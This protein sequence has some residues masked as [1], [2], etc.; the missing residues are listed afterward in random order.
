MGRSREISIQEVAQITGW[1]QSSIRALGVTGA[2]NIY[3]AEHGHPTTRCEDARR[4]GRYV[5]DLA[6]DARQIH[7]SKHE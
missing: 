1:S 6:A 2:L 5:G 4:N 3:L 7:R